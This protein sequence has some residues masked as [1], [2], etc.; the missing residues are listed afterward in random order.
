MSHLH[1]YP[2]HFGRSSWYIYNT[3]DFSIQMIFAGRY[4]DVLEGIYKGSIE[5]THSLSFLSV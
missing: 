1:Y 4:T 5:P 2:L 3:Y